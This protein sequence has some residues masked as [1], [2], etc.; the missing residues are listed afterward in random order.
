MRQEVWNDGI[1]DMGMMYRTMFL[2]L[3][4]VLKISP[5]GYVFNIGFG[6]ELVRSGDEVSLGLYEL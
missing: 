1:K 3:F 5:A 2:L 6:G 4:F